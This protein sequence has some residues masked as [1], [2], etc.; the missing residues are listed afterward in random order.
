MLHGAQEQPQAIA[1]LSAALA[2]LSPPSVRLPWTQAQCRQAGAEV[3][4]IACRLSAKQE[5]TAA[6]ELFDALAPLAAAADKAQPGAQPSEPQPPAD[7]ARQAQALKLLSYAALRHD[8]EAV[9]Y[10]LTQAKRMT[11]AVLGAVLAT[12]ER[13]DPALVTDAQLTQLAALANPDAAYWMVLGWPERQAV[14][15]SRMAALVR[16]TPGQENAMLVYAYRL[17]QARKQAT[18]S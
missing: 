1:G 3:E 15:D 2:Q 17:F 8:A 18:T 6:I 5:Q 4:Y 14:V 12:L 9:A 16:V 13:H 7:S 10:V 11:P